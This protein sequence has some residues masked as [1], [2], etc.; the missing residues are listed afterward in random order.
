[1]L[2]RVLI[3]AHPHSHRHRSIFCD[4][5]PFQAANE[6][7]HVHLHSVCRVGLRDY[8][9]VAVRLL[10]ADRRSGHRRPGGDA[11]RRV[12]ADRGHS[13]AVRHRHLHPAVLP[14]VPNYSHLLSVHILQAS[15]QQKESLE[16]QKFKEEAELRENSAEEDFDQPDAGADGRHLRRLLAAA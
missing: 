14:A 13:E 6:A 4:N 12:V 15:E 5:F 11:V 8:A 10:H 3:D 9:D 16:E 1:M 7:L 2:L